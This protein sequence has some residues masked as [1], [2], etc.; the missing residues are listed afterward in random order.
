MRTLQFNVIADSRFQADPQTAMI[1]MVDKIL[2]GLN[3]IPGVIAI[4]RNNR[5]LSFDGDRKGDPKTTSHRTTIHVQ[6][7]TRRVTWN[8]IYGIINQTQAAPYS[9]VNIAPIRNG[10]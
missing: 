7:T 3:G 10:G 5:V 1:M 4:P 2:R 9:F 8:D 6:K